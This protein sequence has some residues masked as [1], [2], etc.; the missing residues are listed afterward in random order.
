MLLIVLMFYVQDSTKAGLYHLF[1]IKNGVNGSC[2]GTHERLVVHLSS[3][4]RLWD[5]G[6]PSVGVFLREPS[7]YFRELRRKPRKTLN[8]Y[9]DKRDRGLN[10]APSVFHFWTLPLCNWWGT[11]D[12]IPI[13]YYSQWLN[14]FKSIFSYVY[15]TL[16]IMKLTCF[17]QMYQ[18]TFV[19]K[20]WC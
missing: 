9:V 13:Y 18:I 5:L 7:P 20:K 4:V 10:L 1:R 2:S 14:V 15:T 11:H 12:R 6:M 8:A 19:I 16:N 3:I 17:I